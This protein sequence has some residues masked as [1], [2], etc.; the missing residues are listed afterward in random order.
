[1]LIDNYEIEM[2]YQLLKEYLPKITKPPT[3][4]SCGMSKIIVSV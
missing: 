2:K 4:T 3:A 1:M